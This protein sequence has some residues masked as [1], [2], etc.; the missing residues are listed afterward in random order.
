MDFGS[1]LVQYAALALLALIW[2][3]SFI[4]MKKG[5]VHFDSTEVAAYRMS[6]AMLVLLPIALRNL[7]VLRNH[8]RPLF[9]VGLVGN[10]VPAFLF[11]LAQTEIPSSLSGM[12]NA[13]TSLFTLVLGVLFFR[14]RPLRTQVLGVFVALV[15]TMGLIGFAQLLQLNVHGRY[16]LLVVAATACY[17]TAVNLIKSYLR[18]I[19]SR[20]ITSLSFLITAPFLL[21]YLLVFTD[22]VPQLRSDPESWW[23]LLYIS[24]LG[25]LSTALALILFNRLI[26]HTTALFASSVTYLIPVFAV[27]WGVLDGETIDTGQLGYLLVILG[28]IFLINLPPGLLRRR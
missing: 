27:A 21:A 26:K 20:H 9:F 23:G 13:L 17:G 4:L 28:G 19:P 6:I 22:F 2:G 12:L 7:S 15:G 8:W 18:E 16:S 1:R 11:A 14:M 3:S 10:T 25:I 24:L 5:L